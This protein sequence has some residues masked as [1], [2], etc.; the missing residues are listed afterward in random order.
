MYQGITGYASIGFFS[1]SGCVWEVKRKGD[2]PNGGLPLL[3][4]PYGK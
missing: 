2:T 3:C 1:A 4:Y